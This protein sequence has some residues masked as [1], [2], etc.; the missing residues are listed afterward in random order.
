MSLTWSIVLGPS[1]DTESQRGDVERTDD[2][3]DV[4]GSAGNEIRPMSPRDIGRHPRA[5]DRNRTGDI[6]LGKLT[7][8]R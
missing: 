8:Y 5:G 4:S 6:Q 3:L 1:A 2:A 7:F